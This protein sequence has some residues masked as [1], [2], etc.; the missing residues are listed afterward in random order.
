MWVFY[1]ELTT[2][3]YAMSTFISNNIAHAELDFLKLTTY[4]VFFAL[5][6]TFYGL[7]LN[8]VRDVYITG[9]SFI[10]RLRA[11]QR[12]QTATRNMDERYPDATEEEMTAMSDR[13]CIICRE[14]MVLRGPPA[15]NELVDTPGIESQG[16]TPGRDGPNTTP[17]KLPCGHFFH[18]HC[19][20]SWLERQQ[21]CPTWS[22]QP[23]SLI[24]I[25]QLIYYFAVAALY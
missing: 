17:K 13:I 1:I 22:V 6:I 25:H 14:E 20:R 4:L 2:G 12:Y 18:F 24:S 19:L 23:P 3:N 10:T 9:R 5:I 8:I 15:A 16:P 21:N 7:P 11:L